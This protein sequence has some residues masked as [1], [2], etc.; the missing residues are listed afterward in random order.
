M[1]QAR[2][3][4]W[5]DSDPHLR[6]ELNFLDP[7]SPLV[8]TALLLLVSWFERYPDPFRRIHNHCGMRFRRGRALPEDK[9]DVRFPHGRESLRTDVHAPTDFEVDVGM[10]GGRRREDGFPSRM[11]ACL[12]SGQR[13]RCGHDPDL[14][15]DVAE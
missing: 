10:R 13:R 12:R 8:C 15:R 11:S 1:D 6:R 3:E 7:Y 14:I 2:G 9:R 4:R 5:R